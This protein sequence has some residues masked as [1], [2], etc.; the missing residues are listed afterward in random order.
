MTERPVHSPLLNRFAWF[1]AA[2]TLVLICIGGLVT[3][4]GA[5]MAVPDWP[6]TYGYNLFLFPVSQWVGGILYEH[7]HRLVAA[8]VGLLTAVLA[9]WLWIRETEGRLRWSGVIVMVI[10]VALLG[11]RAMPVYVA[12]ALLALPVTLWALIRFARN[13]GGLRWLGVT[14]LAAVILQGV[15][16]GL[17][18]AWLADEIGVF[19]G[20][21]AQSFFMLTVVIALMT[22]DRWTRAE[23][24]RVPASVRRTFLVV[25]ALIF[26][27]L[28][29]GAAMRH[30]HAGLA[31]PDFPL[32]HGRVWP[33]TDPEALARYNQQR[34][35]VH[36]AR[37]ITATDVVLHMTHRAWACVVVAAVVVAYA[38]AR[39]QLPGGHPLRRGAAVWLG[40]I[41][42]QFALGAITVWTN[43]AADIA[44]AHVAVGSLALVAGGVLCLLASRRSLL[45]HL[46]PTPAR[47]PAP[48]V[49]PSPQCT[50]LSP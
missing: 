33:R 7:S 26:V 8:G 3:S 12:L 6:N 42:V 5:G 44:T 37:A 49:A 50:L 41:S 13:P 27:Q 45:A 30:R 20:V 2:A 46:V 1:T 35:E 18:V 40:L 22:T 14:A 9:V 24:L 11:A 39:R 38:R 47:S 21:L 16:G 4:K 48:S 28:G 29:L 19:H 10:A 32:A 15:L 23:D 17:R 34:V 31:V 36:A 25:T 43:K